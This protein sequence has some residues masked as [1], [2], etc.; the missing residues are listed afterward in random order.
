M[1]SP[2]TLSL[3][4]CTEQCSVGQVSNSTWSQIANNQIA[5]NLFPGFGHAM[6]T[7]GVVGVA[8]DAA[9]QRVAQLVKKAHSINVTVQARDLWTESAAKPGYV[10]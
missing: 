8:G 10:G 6:H 4:P 1:W 7:G 2:S 5:T 3:S 9:S